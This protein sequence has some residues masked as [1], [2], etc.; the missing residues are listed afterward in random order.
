MTTDTKEFNLLRHDSHFV[1]QFSAMASPCELLIDSDNEAL[2]KSLSRSCVAE[3]SRIEEKFSRYISN[4]ACYAINN[5]DGKQTQIDDECY[6][7]LEFAETCFELS[8]GMFD[9]TSGVLRRVWHF[10]GGSAL[11]DQADIDSIL[12]LVGWKNV[13]YDESSIQMLPGMEIDFGGIGKEYAVS[14]VSDMCR[15]ACPELSVLVNLGGDIQVTRPRAN[16]EPWMV[17]IENDDKVIPISQG[18]LATS[19]EAKRYLKKDGVRYSHILNPKTGWPI[20]GAPASVT[21]SAPL[22]IQAGCIATLALLNGSKAEHFLK[23]Q[24]VQYWLS[25]PSESSN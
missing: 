15:Q 1:T 24:G 12:P 11:P 23:E 20:E 16:Q 14:R 7:L 3:V 10:D 8:N 9:L 5:S 21:I 13:V 18:A 19:G 2:A 17:G 22:C 4:N 25:Y 6:R